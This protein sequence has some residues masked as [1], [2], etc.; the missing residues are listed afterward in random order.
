MSCPS[1]VPGRDND[2]NGTYTPRRIICALALVTSDISIAHSSHVRRGR[3]K[4]IYPPSY[5]QVLLPLFAREPA[6]MRYIYWLNRDLYRASDG[7]PRTHSER[8]QGRA[9]RRNV[10]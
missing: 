10:S 8:C 5:W 2:P 7:S 9:F 3:R 4:A 6:F 1:L